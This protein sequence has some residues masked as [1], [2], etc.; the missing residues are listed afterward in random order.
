MNKNKSCKK[1]CVKTFIP[2]RERVENEFDKRNP[3]TKYRYS[4]VKRTNKSLAKIM[5]R[6]FITTCENIYCQKKCK[7]TKNRFL[8]SFSKKR[9]QKLLSQGAI[10]GCRNL[11]KE[12]P[13]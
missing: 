10:S 7:N 5:K 4:N 13:T 8:T 1:F 12:F 11:I 2:E 9:K 3:S 6:N